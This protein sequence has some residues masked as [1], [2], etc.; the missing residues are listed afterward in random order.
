[1]RILIAAVAAL[2]LSGCATVTRGTTQ[3]F[4]ITTVPAGA[5]V[6]TSNGFQ[7]PSTPCTLKMPRRPGFTVEVSLPGYQTQTL[8]VESSMSGGGGAALAG[9]VIIGG[10]IGAGVDAT[11][12]ALNDLKPNPLEVILVPVGQ[13]AAP[14]PVPAPGS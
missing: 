2:S 9:N 5:S 6:S 4:T 12:G 10:V 7:C 8:T 14:A 3:E 13:A 11:S 1:M